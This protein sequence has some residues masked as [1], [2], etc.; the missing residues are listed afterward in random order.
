MLRWLLLAEECWLLLFEHV[1]LTEYI[2]M[3]WWCWTT[4]CWHWRFFLSMLAQLTK[5]DADDAGWFLT[6][7]V[8]VCVFSMWDRLNMKVMLM[9]AGCWMLSCSS[10]ACWL[11]WIEV[12]LLLG[13]TSWCC[14]I[15]VEMFD[16]LKRCWYRVSSSTFPWLTLPPRLSLKTFVTKW[17]PYWFPGLFIIAFHV[18]PL[19]KKT[20]NLYWL[21][22]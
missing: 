6:I 4:S 19:L 8:E 5:R 3:W 22:T 10:W 16:Q 2:Y 13:S 20:L 1:G 7:Y 17:H 12:M 18:F 11:G 15:F 14:S 9:I 21:H